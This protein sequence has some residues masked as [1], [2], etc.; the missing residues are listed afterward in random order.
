[1]GMMTS[2]CCCDIDFLMDWYGYMDNPESTTLFSRVS[3]MEPLSVYDPDVDNEVRNGGNIEAE[4]NIP[5]TAPIAIFPYLTR[6][7]T[8][9]SGDEI[10]YRLEQSTLPFRVV[11]YNATTKTRTWASNLSSPAWGSL[12]GVTSC[13]E[14]EFVFHHYDSSSVHRSVRFDSV[15]TR[16]TKTHAQP[17]AGDTETAYAAFWASRAC[18]RACALLLEVTI[19]SYAAPSGPG[20][21]AVIGFDA[22]W[23]VIAGD[24]P[25]TDDLLVVTED[26]VLYQETGSGVAPGALGQDYTTDALRKSKVK[27]WLRGGWEHGTPGALAESVYPAWNFYPLLT[28]ER[29]DSDGTH[30]AAIIELFDAP[31]TS[32]VLAGI[33]EDDL[34]RGMYVV[35]NGNTRRMSGFTADSV[36]YTDITN[37]T[38]AHLT[39]FVAITNSNPAGVKFALIRSIIIDDDRSIPGDSGSITGMV[40]E[41]MDSNGSLLDSVSMAT[42]I[43]SG[44]IT[45]YPN[46]DVAVRRSLAPRIAGF[47]DRYIYVTNFWLD[48]SDVTNGIFPEDG[49]SLEESPYFGAWAIS[50]DLSIYNPCR[51]L[52]KLANAS[53]PLSVWREMNL[54]ESLIQNLLPA[55][56]TVPVRA[57]EQVYDCI[58][59]SSLPFSPPLQYIE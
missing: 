41:L 9:S 43:P 33:T 2:Y 10:V 6:S 24:A 31:T 49:Y 52:V 47:S 32:E 51:R 1:M 45:G 50:Y 20:D 17:T 46:T 15:G 38:Q 23:K 39:S 53:G 19:T 5:V 59:D 12:E 30:D 26:A 21:W 7:L 37:L 16:T 56:Y 14:D 35:A 27:S 55:S 11:R 42:F 58:K 40:L 48:A 25:F 54:A 29:Y 57:R 28:I 13:S 36:G 18:P 3:S 8:S 22:T 4:W 34:D 44:T